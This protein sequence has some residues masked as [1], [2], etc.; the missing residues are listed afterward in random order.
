MKKWLSIATV[1]LLGTSLFALADDHKGMKFE[2]RK[3][4]VIAHIGKRIDSLN[5]F[6]SCVEAAQKGGLKKCRQENK[7][8]MSAF[9]EERRA[10]RKK[11]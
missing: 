9:K 5:Q 4:K 1:V 8:R 3:A 6:K 11:K 10:M 7:A 2:E